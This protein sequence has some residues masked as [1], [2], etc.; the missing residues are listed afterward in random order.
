MILDFIFLRCFYLFLLKLNDVGLAFM[1]GNRV[2]EFTLKSIPLS[3]AHLA[4]GIFTHAKTV[5][6][7]AFTL[8]LILIPDDHLRF[9]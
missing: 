4:Q 5:V 2:A 7:V 6:N 8:C 9:P 3:L 1:M